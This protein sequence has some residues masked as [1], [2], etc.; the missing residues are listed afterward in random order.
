[1]IN[2]ILLILSVIIIFEFINY[3]KL[4]NL[5]K[6]NFEACKK[7]IKF[8]TLKNLSD[9]EKENIIFNDAKKLLIISLKVLL[10][11]TSII[12]YLLVLNFLSNSFLKLII[13]LT[14]FVE[15]SIISLIY[16]FIKKKVNAKLQ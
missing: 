15:I 6:L 7:L 16:Y 8:F 3:T 14:G 9:I 10:V 12:F 1:M 13:S 5:I 4:L 2:H 11:L